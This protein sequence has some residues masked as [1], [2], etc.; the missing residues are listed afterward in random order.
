MIVLLISSDPHHSIS[1]ADAYSWMISFYSLPVH[2]SINSE[3]S[4]TAWIGYI[5]GP[6]LGVLILA[7]QKPS[8]CFF[9]K[10]IPKASARLSLGD[11]FLK[12]VRSYK[13]PGVL[14]TPKLKFDSHVKDNL[15]PNVRRWA[16]YVSHLL[17]KIPTGR[18]SFARILW[19]SKTH[20][21]LEYGSPVWSSTVSKSTLDSI[22]VFQCSFLRKS[23]GLPSFTSRGGLLC[24]LAVG[25]Q[26]GR[27][28]RERI[29]LE[30]KIRYSLCPLSVLQH[31]AECAKVSKSSRVTFYTPTTE[32]CIRDRVKWVV[33]NRDKVIVPGRATF[34]EYFQSLQENINK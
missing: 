25:T 22:D 2:Q 31:H 15:L 12:C 7:L 21:I 29:K 1:F 6:I 3:I 28:E 27:F 8:I 34:E 18:C 24:D 19:Q 32:Q 13:Y 33:E 16:G 23:M 11:M 10:T 20:P 9:R 17:S 30:L 4:S 14:F 26:S 5:H